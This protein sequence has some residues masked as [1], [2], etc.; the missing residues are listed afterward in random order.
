MF[1]CAGLYDVP[2]PDDS[3]FLLTAIMYTFIPCDATSYL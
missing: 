3:E 1:P 2:Y